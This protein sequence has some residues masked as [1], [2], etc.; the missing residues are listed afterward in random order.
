LSRARS[1]S[2]PTSSRIQ[3][4]L[5]RLGYAV[6]Q[7]DGAYGVATVVAVRAFQRGHHLEV[8]GVVGPQTR[9]RRRRRHAPHAR[10]HEVNGFGRV[11]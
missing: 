7:L 10:A 4:R 3:R 5:D 1:P 8:D 2:D 11:D 6:G 9:V